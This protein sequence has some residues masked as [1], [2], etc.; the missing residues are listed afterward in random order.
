MEGQP[1]RLIWAARGLAEG[2]AEGIEAM[3]KR[4]SPGD[5]HEGGPG[6]GGGAGLRGQIRQA[7][8]R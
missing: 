6:G 8:L 5:H 3:M 1:A 2:L 4:F 7:T